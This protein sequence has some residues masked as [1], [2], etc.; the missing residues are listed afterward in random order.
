M[1]YKRQFINRDRGVA[2][3]SY[4]TGADYGSFSISDCHRAP[5]AKNVQHWLS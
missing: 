3:M 5:P 2:A 1:A 4:I